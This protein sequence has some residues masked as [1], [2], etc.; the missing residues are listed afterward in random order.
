M[1]LSV[2]HSKEQTQTYSVLTAN[3]KID[4]SCMSTLTSRLF[5][6]DSQKDSQ[7]S[8]VRRPAIFCIVKMPDHAWQ[9]LHGNE[10]KLA[11]TI[12]KHE[13]A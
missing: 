10:K 13:I 4:S 9:S 3:V 6:L 11:Q 7:P 8:I 2:S 12:I 1:P 5:S